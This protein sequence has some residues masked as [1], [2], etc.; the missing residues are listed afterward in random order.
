MVRT[1][2]WEPWDRKLDGYVIASYCL[3]VCKLWH[4]LVQCRYILEGHRSTHNNHYITLFV[5]G[6]TQTRKTGLARPNVGTPLGTTT[7]GIAEPKW[8]YR[9]GIHKHS[10]NSQGI[11]LKLLGTRRHILAC[12]DPVGNIAIR[13]RNIF[14]WWILSWLVR[15]VFGQL[16]ICAKPSAVWGF[17]CVYQSNPN[18][19]GNTK[20]AA[21]RWSS[22]R[23]HS[24]MCRMVRRPCWYVFAC[25]VWLLMRGWPGAKHPSLLGG[26]IIILCWCAALFWLVI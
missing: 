20:P 5:A 6:V 15:L 10:W 1:L 7:M 21:P 25:V 16:A 18:W 23:T 26:A 19:F 17:I 4:V 2:C 13:P 12:G 22:A 24:V 9:I 11:V 3:C 8:Q 14:A